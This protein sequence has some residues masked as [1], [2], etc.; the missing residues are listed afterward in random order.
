MADISNELDAIMKARYGKDVRQSIHDGIKKVNENVDESGVNEIIDIRTDADGVTHENAGAAVRHMDKELSS[1]ISFKHL[2]FSERGILRTSGYSDDA[3]EGMH[4]PM[5]YCKDYNYLKYTLNMGASGLAV[6][7]YGASKEFLSDVSIV[8]TGPV[9]DHLI[10]IPDTAYYVIVAT[11]N[12]L[13]NYLTPE[14]ATLYKCIKEQDELFSRNGYIDTNGDFVESEDSKCTNFIRTDEYEIFSFS[15]TTYSYAYAIAAYDEDKNFIQS[16]SKQGDGTYKTFNFNI[17]ENAKYLVF[18]SLS[19]I[20]PVLNLKYKD[21]Y[22]L[23]RRV[24]TL[25]EKSEQVEVSLEKVYESINDEIPAISFKHLRFSERG[26]LRTSGYS[27]DAYEGMH[28]PMIY[29]KDYNYLKYTLNMGASGLAV[30]FYGASKEFLSDVSIVGTGPVYDHLIRIPD[31]AYYVIVATYNNLV[32]YLTPEYATLYKCIKEQDELFS[33][34]GYIDTNGDFVESEDSKCTNFIRTDEYEIFSFSATTYSYAYA[35]A[36]YDEDKN[37]IQSL[38]KQ[39]DGTYKTFNFNI[40]ENAKYLVFTSLSNITPVLNLKYKDGYPLERRVQTLEEKSE[41]VS[42]NGAKVL[43]FGDS[44]TDSVF[45]ENDQETHAST[46][47]NWKNPGNSE[48]GVGYNMWPKLLKDTY[49]FDEI[50]CYAK[51]GASWRNRSLSEYRQYV[52]E[53]ID[54]AFADLENPNGLFTDSNF[55]PDIVIFALGTNDGPEPNDSYEM[56]LSKNVYKSG[57]TNIDIEATI[58]ALDDTKFNEAIRKNLLRIINK[59]PSAQIYVVLPI[60]RA[61]QELIFDK[62]SE[63]IQKMAERHSCII[64]D[65]GKAF[66]IRRDDNVWESS[67]SLLKD[68]LHPNAIGQ[69]IMARGIISSLMRNFVNLNSIKGYMD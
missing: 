27:D 39:G 37:F 20:T 58:N 49:S 67:G 17:N 42:I 50:R 2:R 23:E 57:G 61:D 33:R 26:I 38:S 45:I 36:A 63:D 47:Y 60:Q 56:A 66:G 69:K 12:N 22:P 24:Q 19:N 11:Y 6:G 16:L 54:N 10:R 31:T 15:A 35:I 40:N 59:F 46:N 1:A 44:I 64:V 4:T 41:Q 7:F 43:I 52:G 25:E 28:T 55:L 14:Y 8:G 48:N 21:G 53:Q 3:Y 68:G 30:G 13:V 34:N 9:Y 32:N 18:T 62:R 51:S 29:C 5:I 65:G